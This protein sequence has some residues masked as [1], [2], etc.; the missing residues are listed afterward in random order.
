MSPHRPGAALRPSHFRPIFRASRS[1]SLPAKWAS[2]WKRSSSSRLTRIPSG[3]SPEGEGGD[4]KAAGTLERYPDDFD[5]KKALSNHTGLD[6]SRIV[7]GNGSNDVLDL[8]AR[9]FLASGRS[10]VFS[11]HAFAVYP[12]ATLGRCRTDCRAGQGFRP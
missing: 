10:A 5:L 1:P 9:V 3:M 7:L 8:I 11:Q 2:R 12:L 4:G 6:M